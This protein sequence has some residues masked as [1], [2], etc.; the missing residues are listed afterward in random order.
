MAHKFCPNCGTTVLARLP[1]PDGSTKVGINIRAFQDVDLRAL[2]VVTS[3]KGAS[4]EPPYKIP[5]AVG[6]GPVP[7]GSTVYNGSCHCGAVR[8][9]LLN[10]EK[11]TTVCDCNCSICSRDAALWIYPATASITF[12]GLEE[13]AVEYGFGEKKVYHGFCKICGVALFER[14]VDEEDRTTAL[15]VRAIDGVDLATLEFEFDDGKAR[16]P[17]YEV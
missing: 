11:I 4:A 15:N 3:T 17:F 8:F 1:S 10:P 13:S 7:E 5:E 2:E 9:A 6:A 12:A 14:F 16:P